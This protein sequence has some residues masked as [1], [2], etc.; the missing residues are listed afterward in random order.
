MTKRSKPFNH[1]PTYTN[2]HEAY[3]RHQ[4]H[5][6]H[7]RC[8]LCEVRGLNHPVIPDRRLFDLFAAGTKP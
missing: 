7:H 1:E 2:F 5:P 8:P 3:A 4:N 6:P